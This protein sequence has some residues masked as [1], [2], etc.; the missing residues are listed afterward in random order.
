[1]ARQTL[2]ILT[3]NPQLPTTKALTRYLHTQAIEVRYLNPFG[4]ISL[5][6]PDPIKETWLLPRT[7]GILFDDIDLHLCEAWIAAGAHCLIPLNAIKKLRDKDRQYL[8]L[9][10]K[11][12]PMVR[13]LIH[14][15][16][17]KEE[18][19]TQLAS[20]NSEW[21]IK[22]IRGNKG[23]GIEK[24]TTGELLAFWK[25]ALEKN[26]QRYLIQEFLTPA[27]ECRI[28]CLANKL[29]A[30]EKVS[31]GSD[32]KKNAQYAK[33]EKANLKDHEAQKFLEYAQI[34][35]QELNLP[36]FAIDLINNHKNNQWQILEVNV[37]PGLEASSKAMD[38]NLYEEYWAALLNSS[39]AQQL[40]F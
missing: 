40:S 10:E 23:I 20:S 19:L 15:G 16:I 21:I 22:S 29:Y 4:E 28:L 27:R 24:F 9:R 8:L 32:W 25:K 17:L 7:S 18:H 39:S 13:T 31:I 11:G 12:L 3:T 2:L 6:S 34:I 33:F 5:I 30:I 36:C 14:R 1:M 37:H 26:D 38:K 35:K